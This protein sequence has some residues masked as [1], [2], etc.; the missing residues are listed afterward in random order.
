MAELENILEDAHRLKKSSDSGFK[1]ARRDNSLE[2]CNLGLYF[3]KPST[4]TRLSFETAVLQLGGSVTN[5]GKNDLHL[6]QGESI[7]DTAK[8]VSL[9]LDAIV[10]RLFNEDHLYEFAKNAK[11]PV[12]NG[13]TNETH[14]CQ[15]L[16]DIFTFQEFRGSI[17]GKT[18]V[19]FG[20]ANNVLTSFLQ[21]S[22][23]FNFKIVFCGPEKFKPKKKVLD[24][25]SDTKKYLFEIETDPLKAIKS[26][27][28]IVTDKWVSMH[29]QM[30]GEQDLEELMRYQINKSLLDLGKQEVILMHCLP[31]AKGLEVTEEIFADKRSVVFE[32]AE[33]RMHLQKAILRWCLKK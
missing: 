18:V 3:E 7:E 20:V 6:N 29:D 4:R 24:R 5:I 32:E 14:P 22:V 21:A 2:G 11:I 13:L 23:H 26:A 27:D 8:V 1:G 15:I 10:L 31:A 17:E 12:I 19:W 16:T 30:L 33:N 25:L 28:L 9:F